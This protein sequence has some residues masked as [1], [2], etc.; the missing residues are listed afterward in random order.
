[1][2]WIKSEKDE[3]EEEEEE[4]T[5][6]ESPQE[7][8]VESKIERWREEEWWRPRTAIRFLQRVG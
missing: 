5:L 4:E 6:R 7:K 2:G 1:M 8:Q 3:P